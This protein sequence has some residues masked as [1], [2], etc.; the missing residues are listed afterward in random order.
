[1][2]SKADEIR[3]KAQRMKERAA[4]HDQAVA[5][6]H[7]PARP[8]SAPHVQS[9]PVRSTVDLAPVMHAEL[10]A[11]CGRTAVELGRSRVTTQDVMRALVGRLLT[12][13]KLA[14]EIRADISKY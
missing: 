11:W 3:A 1:M 6:H 2:V 8:R 12:D 9:R 13:P 14:A 10:K 4:E 7:E 5:E